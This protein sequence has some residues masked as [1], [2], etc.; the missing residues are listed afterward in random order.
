MNETGL[1]EHCQYD[2][3][4]ITGG[5]LCPTD[6]SLRSNIAGFIQGYTFEVLI[7]RVGRFA[8][9]KA[10]LQSI[11][12]SL[13]LHI[14]VHQT[15]TLVEWLRTMPLFPLPE[16]LGT[17]VYAKVGDICLFQPNMLL[18]TE[19]GKLVQIGTIFLSSE[20]M[21]QPSLWEFVET[22][23]WLDDESWVEEWTEEENRL[24]EAMWIEPFQEPDDDYEVEVD[25]FPYR[26]LT[27]EESGVCVGLMKRLYPNGTAS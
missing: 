15:V 19:D 2:F 22:E 24:I 17:G 12:F 8:Q 16:V 1:P 3:R 5:G 14:P 4:T 11:F 21:P 18:E 6:E 23:G 25:V 27:L 20:D 10:Q 13:M 9:R 7:E 26:I